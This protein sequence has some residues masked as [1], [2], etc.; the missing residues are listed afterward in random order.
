[1]ATRQGATF[2]DTL[3][4]TPQEVRMIDDFVA[5]ALSGSAPERAA[6]VRSTLLTQ[7]YLD[8]IW[9]ARV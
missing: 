8:A 9:A 3:S 7:E 6:Y 2:V 4:T 5:L 1:M